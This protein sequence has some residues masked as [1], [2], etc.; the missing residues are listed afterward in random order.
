LWFFPAGEILKFTSGGLPG[1]L[2]NSIGQ[3][4]GR[5]QAEG[6]P[7]DGEDM[8]RLGWPNLYDQ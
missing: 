7:A 6:L 4:E 1:T 5:R 8:E 3:A 2:K